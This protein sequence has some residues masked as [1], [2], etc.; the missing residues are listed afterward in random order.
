VAT[1]AGVATAVPPTSDD[2]IPTASVGEVQRV[3]N[4]SAAAE[5]GGA[6][7]VGGTLIVHAVVGSSD[8]AA[9]DAVLAFAHSHAQDV[10]PRSHVEFDTVARSLPTLRRIS[11]DILNDRVFTKASKATVSSWGVDVSSNRVAIT[12][13]ARNAAL[14]AEATSKYGDA[15]IFSVAPLARALSRSADTS[16]Y[17]A[18]GRIWNQQSGAGCTLGFAVIHGGARKALTAGHCGALTNTWKNGNQS[19]FVG[20]TR[21]RNYSNGGWDAELV[22]DSNY[23]GKVWLGGTTSTTSKTVNGMYMPSNGLQVCTSGATSGERC[24]AFV[25]DNAGTKCVTK[26]DGLVTCHL[27]QLGSIDG[28]SICQPGDS[29]GPVYRKDALVSGDLRAVGIINIGF[30]SGSACWYTDM[31]QLQSLYGFSIVTS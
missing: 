3:L 17:Y 1:T 23:G 26:D 16:P 21:T 6:S 15:V 14:E 5:S 27:S 12:V 31:Y 20:T 24:N 22:T 18:G 28:F 19:V 9:R 11:D 25:V 7:V 10:G 30:V 13:V 8:R 4:E 29:G 2:N